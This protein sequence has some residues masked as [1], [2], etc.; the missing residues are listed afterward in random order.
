MKK[1]LIE[2]LQELRSINK[3][4]QAI[5]SS[6][7]QKKKI[8]STQKLNFSYQPYSLVLSAS[9]FFLASKTIEFMDEHFDTL[10]KV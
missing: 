1:I 2:I 5:E 6:K 10:M 9:T 7:E 3:K 8:K 4:L